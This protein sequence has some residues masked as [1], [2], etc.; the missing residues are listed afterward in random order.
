MSA[1]SPV[2]VQFDEFEGQDYP[3]D[4]YRDDVIARGVD[5]LAAITD[6]HIAFFREYGYLAVHNAFTQADVDATLAGLLDLIDGKNPE[7]TGVWFEAAVR[8]QLAAMTPEEKQ[9]VVRKLQGFVRFD[10]RLQAMAEHP[11][12]MAA[13]RRILGD[14]PALMQDMALLKPP[15]V[16]R[17]K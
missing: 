1:Q 11:D 12:L 2:S 17:E 14:Q 7:F 9:D 8:D 10:A 5:G 3:P 6:E 13:V 15:G 16:G 4:L